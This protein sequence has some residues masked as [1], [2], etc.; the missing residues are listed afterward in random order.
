MET[1]ENLGDYR[2]MEFTNFV[3]MSVFRYVMHMCDCLGVSC[4]FTSLVLSFYLICS[5]SNPS[6]LSEST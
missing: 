5:V 3:G 4:A 1:D 6:K 2:M